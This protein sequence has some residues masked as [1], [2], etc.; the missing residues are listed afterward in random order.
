M[1][2]HIKPYTAGLW[3]TNNSTAGGPIL[4]RVSL[5]WWTEKDVNHFHL[6]TIGPSL[7]VTDGHGALHGTGGRSSTVQNDARLMHK[8]NP[9]RGDT[10]QN[11]GHLL[12]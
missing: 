12:C 1:S 2:T 7:F 11:G 4:Q 6:H 9:Q 3:R 10:W 8:N 5:M